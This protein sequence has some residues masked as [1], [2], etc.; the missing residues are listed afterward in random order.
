[1]TDEEPM[2]FED[3]RRSFYYGA[4]ADMQFK[5]LARMDDQPAAD[6]VAEVLARVG[7]ALDT[8]DLTGVRDAVY[9]AQ[10][11]AYRGDDTPVVDDAP[12]TPLAAPLPE[13][14]LALISAGGVFRAEDDPMGPD[15]PTQAE[16]LALIK[17][18]LRGAPTLSVIPTDTPDSALTA[19]HPGYDARTAQ[20]D[21]GT[22]F[23]LAVLRELEGEGRVRLA[24]QHYAF[25]G[26]TSQ[27]RLRTQVAPEW[28]RRLPAEG[29]D[30]CLLVA[31]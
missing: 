24:A 31:T 6:A 2:R 25:T 12:F 5:F 15:G 14:R 28:A 17:E 20:R 10:V 11:V 30:A 3:F 22:V 27:V 18:F 7:A 26:A 8:G 13:L 23:P 4:H 1:M 21:P 19:R 16:S 29:V 9:A